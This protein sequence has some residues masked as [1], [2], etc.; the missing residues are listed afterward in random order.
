MKTSCLITIFLLTMLV[1]SGCEKD[2]SLEPELNL[3]PLG[4][5]ATTDGLSVKI[6]STNNFATGYNPLFIEIKDVNGKDAVVDDI[7]VFPIMHMTDKSHSAPWGKV[8]DAAMIKNL[9]A[10]YVV[11]VMPSG[12]M[13]HWELQISF[14]IEGRTHQ[15]VVPVDVALSQNKLVSLTSKA[16]GSRV[17]VALIDPMKPKVGSND[18]ELG[19]WKRKS[20]MEWPAAEYLEVKIEPEMPSMDHGSPN[21]IH[22]VHKGAGM[23]RGKV[24]FTM[25]G[26]WVVHVTI[27]ENGEHVGDTKFDF[28]F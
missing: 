26:W 20:M 19:I 28:E 14:D 16:D 5:T 4:A 24:N 23:Y 6:F 10:C 7:A 21:N 3:I 12:D 9:H 8:N 18:F 13:G 15:A 25:D 1:L 11:F 22:P 17:F 27:N 2:E